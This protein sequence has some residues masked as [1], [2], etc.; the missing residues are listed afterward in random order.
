[1][2]A[3]SG[4]E[5]GGETHKSRIE[6]KEG[7]VGRKGAMR[8]PRGQLSEMNLDTTLHRRTTGGKR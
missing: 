7:Q 4:K 6:L 1:M 2:T 3:E 8:R 5:I